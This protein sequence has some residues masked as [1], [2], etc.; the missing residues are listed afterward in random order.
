MRSNRL[1]LAVWV[2][3]A[4]C[5]IGGSRGSRANDFVS[6]VAF[7]PEGTVKEVRQVRASF[8][9]P[10][11]KF[12]DPRGNGDPFVIHCTASGHGR[13]ADPKNWVFDFDKD[14][15][16]G[17]QCDFKAK[18]DLK[19]ADGKPFG[20][21]REFAFNTG[22]PSITR[23][24]PWEGSSEIDEH[25]AFVLSVD[26]K[27]D[28][29]SVL[30]HAHFEVEGV[31]GAVPVTILD[32]DPRVEGSSGFESMKSKVKLW[33]HKF[34]RPTRVGTNHSGREEVFIQAKQAFPSGAKVTLVWGAGIKALSGM[35]T[36]TDQTF[37]FKV[38]PEFTAEFHCERENAQAGCLPIGTLSLS[39]SAQ[40][41]WKDAKQ[42]RLVAANGAEWKPA[43]SEKKQTPDDE[44]VYSVAFN[45]PFPAETKFKLV[46]PSRLKDDAG[47]SLSNSSRFPLEIATA[48]YPP[49]VK[50]P[51]SFGI[52]EAKPEGVLP[53]TVRNVEPTIQGKVDHISAPAGAVSG[54]VARMQSSSFSHVI[55]MIERVV[56]SEYDYQHRDESILSA[57]STGSEL[58]SIS[59]PKPNGEKA[60]EVMGIPLKK[61]GFYVVELESA[62]LGKALLAEDHPMFVHAG[63]LVTNLS[64]HLKKGRE[65]S[66]V[67]VTA[68]DSGKPVAGAQVSLHT[69][70]GNA[71][72]SG[73]TDSQGI[74]K[75]QRELPKDLTERCKRTSTVGYSPYQ[76]GFFAVAEKD[77]DFSFVHSEWNKGIES[78]RFE[79]PRSYGEDNSTIVTTVF[80]RT[81]FRAGE[82]VHMKHFFR[83]HTTSGIQFGSNAELPKSITLE[84]QE[85]N[86]KYVM[87]LQWRSGDTAESTWT[88]PKGAKL[89]NYTVILA[90]KEVKGP[91]GEV[92]ENH[93]GEETEGYHYT[94]VGGSGERS[95]TW[96][97]GSFRVEEF[98][99]P[100]M[101]GRIKPPSE[102]LVGV[103]EVPVD[104]SVEYL[105][106]GGAGKLPVQVRYQTSKSDGLTFPEFEGYQFANGKVVKPGA[107]VESEPSME[108]EEEL[109][110]DPA[111]PTSVSGP[112]NADRSKKQSLNLDSSGLAH[113]TIP[114]P[115]K[116]EDKI[117]NLR[118]ELEYRDPNGETQTN[119]QSLKLYPASRVVGIRPDSWFASKKGLKF[120]V[121]VADLHGKAVAN[122]PVSVDFL[123][124][125][126][127]SHRKRLVGGFYAYE[128]K[129]ELKRLGSA[130]SGKTDETGLLNCDSKPP[131]SGN[132]ILEASSKD[133]KGHLAYANSSTW[134]YDNEEWWFGQSDSDRI[135]L[136]PERKRYEVGEKAVFQVRMPFREATALVTVE[137]EGVIDSFTVPL[138]G[139]KPLI[140]VPILSNYAPN[141][142]V[143]ALVVRGRVGDV[144]PTALVDLG[145]P[146]YKLGVSAIDVGWK[147]HEL[148]VRVT[149]SK[150]VFQVREKGH[151][152][153]HV[154]PADGKRLPKKSEV[155]L[156]AVDEGLLELKDNASW[157]LLD[158]MMNTREYEVETSTAQGEVVGKR[159]FGQKAQA[160]GGDGGKSPSREVFDSLLFWKAD[161]ALDEN[162]DAEVEI[163]MND[164]LTGFKIAAVAHA[165]SQLFGT[166]YT[167][168]RTTQ[169]L[170][171]LSGIPPLA[172]E[173][174]HLSLEFTLRNTTQ[175]PM[176]V[177]VSGNAHGIK[178]SLKQQIVL[179]A[180][181]SEVIKWP[182]EIPSGA[183][184]LK[185]EVEA[186]SLDGH[187]SD[188][189]KVSQKVVPA[190]PTRIYQATLAQ[191]DGKYTLPVE[192]PKD[193][194]AGKGGVRL[195]LDPTILTGLDGVRD[196]MSMYPYSC[197]EQKTSKA[198]AMQDK[199]QW[200]EV[201][202]E[203]PSYL[204]SDGLVRYF[205]S[206]LFAG[207][208]ILS[209]YMISISHEAG[210]D[211]P[212]V[213]RNKILSALKGFVEGRIVR[214]GELPTSDLT[215]RKVAALEALS[216][217]GMATWEM[218]GSLQI[219]PNL[220]PTSALID[221]FQFLKRLNQTPEVVAK[222]AQADQIIRSRLNFQGT[223]MGFSTENI[224]QLWWMMVSTS[225]NSNRLIL[226]LLDEANWKEDMGRIARGSM[227]REHKGHWD[228]TTANAW[229][230][231]A[232]LKFAAA[233][234]KKPVGG[235]T[236]AALQGQSELKLDWKNKPKGDVLDFGWPTSG[237]AALTVSHS[238]SGLP[239]L[240]VQ[241]RA[242]IPLK[243]A[244]ST[245]YRIEKTYTPVE[246]KNKDH[247]SRGDIIRVHLDLESQ[248]DMTWVVVNDPIPAGATIL[249]SG[250][251]NDSS[252][253]S[254]G[255]KAVGWAYTA[256][257]ERAFDGFRAY[258][259][260][261]PKGKWSTEYTIRLN[262][263]GS[264]SMP[265]TRVEAMYAPEFFGERPNA[266][267]SIGE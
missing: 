88:I 247:W 7:S 156:A 209:S 167:S 100:L 31:P 242:A 215:V 244:Y 141:V 102:N 204:D 196:Y 206:S 69:C 103:T 113:V 258:Y 1:G 67:W 146:A 241:S 23:T 116:A 250:L 111:A 65:S 71:L 117:R 140:E 107:E 181:K 64:V 57:P 12:G 186:L 214:I 80:D 260:Y 154:E 199:K 34:G 132:L 49:L 176:T 138:S 188:R 192:M 105:A 127:L 182:V 119:S 197:M 195:I 60:F 261:V 28:P 18:D 212:D 86:Q 243:Q 39:F 226:A 230:T 253:A 218:T 90:Q 22:G 262:Q 124:L 45:G 159:H 133:E 14:I 249:G 131:V 202:S 10:M 198:I 179:L 97:S 52:L 54:K 125:S 200:N 173:G 172:R 123:E 73:T 25:Q 178:E 19:A 183:Q 267:V 162:G 134:V 264:M 251:G 155:I 225:V 26:A 170:M 21:K 20:G 62:R 37:N 227:L 122:A 137:R 59:L 232:M 38:R 44:S 211:I 53:V 190:V 74:W 217:Y 91:S 121:A 231:L 237:G 144:Q 180:G 128:N 248:S 109:D 255:E 120:Q 104:V 2:G 46:V 82:T 148:K 83:R 35:A 175:K 70:S 51:A 207:S 24:N 99:I 201:A 142:Y 47:R 265:A 157:K 40:V 160:P 164:S 72:L 147:P 16:A 221:W 151:F 257:Q 216:R 96:Q 185:Y 3:V 245:G 234:E 5:F 259:A 50:F 87:P 48:D 205:P 236:S 112:E 78:W 41:Y 263:V 95:R 163:P 55:E 8:S 11:T 223:V 252:I 153:V 126:T 79:F 203:L 228:T 75:I 110:L 29:E 152:K 191:V 161:V 222:K 210:W 32:H 136:L 238:G 193:A 92:S 224:D 68:L 9:E 98:R 30:S 219:E 58:S 33:A 171:L 235:V 145:R 135:D 114:V 240:T 93:E 129:T 4:L 165:G 115:A 27:A 77:G 233:F 256:F 130:C 208:D 36:Q 101:R 177:Q 84:H 220:W 43:V 81:L 166:G 139:K 254:A 194:I 174:D 66:L 266:T 108:S 61:P 246:Q 168:I 106:G 94:R 17:V 118:V 169:D 213:T 229:G 184:S 13:W 63:A 76:R 85:S 143:S 6:V 42:I 239:W 15:E 150:N 187:T 158:A 56:S 149:P 189:I 89:G